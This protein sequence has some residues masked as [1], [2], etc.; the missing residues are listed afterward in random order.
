MCSAASLV[1]D[2]PAALADDHRELGLP[3]DLLRLGRGIT[4]SSFAPMSADVNFENSVGCVGTSLPVSR[5]CD[6]V[7]EP[8]AQ[9]LVGTE[10]RGA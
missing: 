2:A 3:V 8:D 4:T 1:G 5:M 7:V 6:A 9:D 10:M